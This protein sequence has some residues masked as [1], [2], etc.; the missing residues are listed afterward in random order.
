MKSKVKVAILDSGINLKHEL[1]RGRDI[2]GGMFE[3][4]GDFREDDVYDTNGHGT[5]CASVI[6]KECREVELYIY[7][8]LDNQLM[9]SLSVLEHALTSLLKSDIRIINL[10]LSIVNRAELNDL[11]KICEK[12]KK[13]GKIIVCAL[14]NGREK[15]YPAY[16]PNTIGVQGAILKRQEEYWFSEKKGIQGVIDSEPF[17]HADLQQRYSFYGKSNSYATAKM[18]GCISNILFGSPN[19]QQSEL[20]RVLAKKAQRRDWNKSDLLESKRFSIF[21]AEE[22]VEPYL[23]KM[24]RKICSSYLNQPDFSLFEQTNMFDR[25]IGLTYNNAF[26]LINIIE[27]EIGIKINNYTDIARSD[28]YSIYRLTNLIQNYMNI[29]FATS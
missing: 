10:S 2:R 26:D 7:K 14:G 22:D 1:F 29:N 6:L 12:L 5:A 8:I 11:K 17:L 9:T 18:T 27:S 16:F 20:H 21:G 13:K 15:S 23:Y 28:L 25:K 3:H 24:I 19:M 4:T